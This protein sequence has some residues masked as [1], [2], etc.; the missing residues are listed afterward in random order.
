V[1]SVLHICVRVQQVRDVTLRQIAPRYY[2][3]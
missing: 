3:E 1:N 2:S